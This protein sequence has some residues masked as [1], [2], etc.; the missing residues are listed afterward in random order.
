MRTMSYSYFLSL[1][2]TH[3]AQGML[4]IKVWVVLDLTIKPKVNQK[5]VWKH[6]QAEKSTKKC[7]RKTIPEMLLK[8][9][10]VWSSLAQNPT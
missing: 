2:C 1:I 4:S 10:I 7:R 3:F 6:E 9:F 8:S 5:A